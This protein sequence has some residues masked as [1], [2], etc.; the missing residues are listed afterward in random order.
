VPSVSVGSSIIVLGSLTG[1]RIRQ[2]TIYQS[3][4]SHLRR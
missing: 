3:T 2:N 4:K 1:I